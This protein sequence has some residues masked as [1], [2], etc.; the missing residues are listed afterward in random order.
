MG[1]VVFGEGGR[2]RMANCRVCMCQTFVALE[3]CSIDVFCYV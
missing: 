2:D 1:C 3:I